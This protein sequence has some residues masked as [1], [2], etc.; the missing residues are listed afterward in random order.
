MPRGDPNEEPWVPGAN[1]SLPA[2]DHVPR[3]W[4]EG[5][6]RGGQEVPHRAISP[7]AARG[8]CRLDSSS[9]SLNRGRQAAC[10]P[11]TACKCPSTGPLAAKAMHRPGHTRPS[12]SIECR[13]AGA[14][15][16]VAVSPPPLARN[17]PSRLASSSG[18]SLPDGWPQGVSPARTARGA[19]RPRNRAAER[20]APASTLY[21]GVLH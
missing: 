11:H 12:E 18:V 14:W 21:T 16:D 3:N 15:K 6:T 17:H 9:R 4:V 8:A 10:R 20:S 1:S 2:I 7:C 5:Q 13:S 19:D